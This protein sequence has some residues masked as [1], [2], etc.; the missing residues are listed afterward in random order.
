MGGECLSGAEGW[1]RAKIRKYDE[2][3]AHLRSVNI[4]KLRFTKYSSTP[5]SLTR[6]PKPVC[7]CYPYHTTSLDSLAGTG[8]STLQ[9]HN[10]SVVQWRS[11][12]KA[13]PC[14]PWQVH[15][16]PR[17]LNHRSVVI[18][19]TG[20]PIQNVTLS[21]FPQT[22]WKRGESGTS[23]THYNGRYTQCCRKGK[24]GVSF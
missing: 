16:V 18:L 6:M 19:R 4:L 24:E 13:R 17:S 2:R 8:I 22:K 1:L 20:W 12:P 11:Y 10:T 21:A 15:K 23:N 7:R 9:Y 14:I 5:G 3:A